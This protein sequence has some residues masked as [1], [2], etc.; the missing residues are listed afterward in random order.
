MNEIY[1]IGM[2]SYL[3]LSG[4]VGGIMDGG[5]LFITDSEENVL[6]GMNN[7]RKSRIR[8]H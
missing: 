8:Y 5:R 1:S 2:L 7:Y 6:A 3:V 4:W